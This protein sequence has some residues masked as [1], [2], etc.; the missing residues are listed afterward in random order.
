MPGKKRSRGHVWDTRKLATPNGSSA[1]STFTQTGG[2]WKT[3]DANDPVSKTGDCCEADGNDPAR[4]TW[5]SCKTADTSDPA[6]GGSSECGCSGD[7]EKFPD[8]STWLATLPEERL[9]T[10]MVWRQRLGDEQFR[11][12][13]MKGT[14]EIHTGEYENFF[15]EGSYCCGACA[16]PLYHSSHKFR[17][18]HGWPAF[19]DSLSGALQRHGQ[20]KVEITCASCDGHIGHVFKSARYPKPHHERHCVNS[21]SLRFVP[22]GGQCEESE[23]TASTSDLREVSSETTW[24]A[25]TNDR[26][27]LYASPSVTT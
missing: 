3:T 5:D 23:L 27:R 8:A 21:V 15:G 17:S 7:V 16:H 4:E 12:M 19:A 13:R 11:V 10:E 24:S 14:E 1:T 22:A 9:E 25:S 6:K 2:S 18:G 20:R 26:E